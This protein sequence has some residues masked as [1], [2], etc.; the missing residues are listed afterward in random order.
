RADDG[1]ADEMA[2]RR[3][4]VFHF[5]DEG[6]LLGGT[7]GLTAELLGPAEAD[8]T[9]RADETGEF[10][11]VAAILKGAAIVHRLALAMPMHGKP[12]A[13]LAPERAHRRIEIESRKGRHRL[14]PQRGGAAG[15]SKQSA[16]CA[17]ARLTPPKR[18]SSAWMRRKC[19]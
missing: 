3:M 13:H 9:F 5:L 15:P 1:L 8:P 17:R 14:P 6:E 12:L 11:I 18:A 10:G 16:S 4:G 2:A 19:R 7:A